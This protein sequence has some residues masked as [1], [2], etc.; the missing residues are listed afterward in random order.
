MTGIPPNLVWGLAATAFT[1]AVA[2]I[3]YCTAGQRKAVDENINKV[4]TGLQK[5]DAQQV[6]KG[7][8]SL[9]K[10]VSESTISQISSD[11]KESEK[12]S[13]KVADVVESVAQQLNRLSSKDRRTALAEIE[14][15]V[16][17]KSQAFIR[18][19]DPSGI[20]PKK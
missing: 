5:Q 19:L 4:A 3:R 10:I 13:E 17:E 7:V 1:A 6:R 2:A 8:D 12:K 15:R 14:G 20:M 9:K 16:E 18:K 11:R